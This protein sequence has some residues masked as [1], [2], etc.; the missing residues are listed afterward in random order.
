MFSLTALLCFISLAS[1]ASLQFISHPIGPNPRNVSFYI[2]VPETLALQP[3]ILV[4]LHGCHGSAQDAFAN[5]K[6]SSLASRYG[7]IIIYP[8]SPNPADKCWDVSSPETLTHNGGG[9]SQGIVSMVQHTLGKYGADP[10][11]V[12]VSGISSG[13]MLTNVLIGSYPDVFAAGAAFAGVPFGCF[14]G[15]GYAEWS[16]ACATGRITHSGQEWAAIVKRAYPSYSS[17]RP[18]MQVYHGTADEVLNYTNF[19]EEIREWTSVYGISKTPVSTCLDTPIMGWTRTV[20]GKGEL[21]AYSAA[22]V[23]HDIPNQED[24][25]MKFFDLTCMIGGCFRRPGSTG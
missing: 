24:V 1:A 9:D 13:A 12:F 10:S 2:Y 11:R 4:F 25:V 6:Y 3:P 8:D 23:T 21:E 19:G 20:Y 15:T 22:N 7:F 14:A 17:Y 5:S 18:K 16:D